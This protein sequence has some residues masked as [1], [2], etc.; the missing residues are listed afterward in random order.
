[1]ETRK[2]THSKEEA[3]KYRKDENYIETGTDKNGNLIFH[4]IKIEDVLSKIEKQ[5]YDLKEKSDEYISSV[6]NISK[7]TVGCYR[8]KIKS[9]GF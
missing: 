2:F 4:S 1:M 3:A 9:K 7:K 5:V 8:D 6:L